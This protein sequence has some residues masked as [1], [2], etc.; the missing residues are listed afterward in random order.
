MKKQ[1]SAASKPIR[2]DQISDFSFKEAYKSLRANLVFSL[3]GNIACRKLLFTSSTAG[4]GKT[5]VSVNTAITLAEASHKVLLIDGD[6]RK[7]TIHRYF[8]IY[9]KGRLGL[10]NL[11]SGVNN[12][13]ECCYPIE[14]V[15]N[16]YVIPAGTLPPNPSELLASV[17]MKEL[18]AQ[19][20]KQ[21]EYILIDTPPIG[22]VTDA[23][24]LV[25]QVD[26]VAFVATV[27][28]SNVPEISRSLSKL[29]FAGANVLGFVVNKV[30]KKRDYYNKNA[31]YHYHSSSSHE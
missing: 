19:L 12:L 18:L 28:H 22:I 30:A 15:P 1:S 31:Y 8:G 25:N 16:L 7:P 24:S 6:L 3:P 9:A 26:G 13:D 2:V 4:D 27:G 17:P 11:L 21:F 5:T 20:E 23:I 29:K 14:S 10:S